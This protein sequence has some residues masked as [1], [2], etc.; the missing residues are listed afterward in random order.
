[1][2]EPDEV[3]I[4]LARSQHEHKGTDEY[5]K[6]INKCSKDKLAT[7]ITTIWS[8]QSMQFSLILEQKHYT[9]V[10]VGKLVQHNGPMH[11]HRS[12]L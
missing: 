1:M 12:R 6:A 3:L 4:W 8:M 5:D 9:D 11:L 7:T 10:A 2:A